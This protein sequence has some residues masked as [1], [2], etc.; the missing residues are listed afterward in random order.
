LV[1]YEE[2][3]N[4][5]ID[6]LLE[7][8]RI[9]RSPE[10]CPWDREQSHATIKKNLIEEAYE[11]AETIEQNDNAGLCEE[12][13]DVLLQIVF[14]AQMAT[15]TGEFDF[16]KVC[17]GI[18]KK[19]ILRHPHVFGEVKADTADKVLDNWAEIKKTEKGQADT[20]DVMNAVARSLP[21]LMRGQKIAKAAVK[22]GILEQIQT[23]PAASA[24][25]NSLIWEAV[26]LAAAEKLDAEEVFTDFLNNYISR[27]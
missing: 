14:H 20:A 17:D 18:C 21:A 27:E 15:E 1:N 16:D 19:L 25:I 11:A 5:T 3:S 22:G 12:L 8:M 26:R 9:L 13:G 10:G 23:Q 7:I 24:K 2:K 4:Y 6:D